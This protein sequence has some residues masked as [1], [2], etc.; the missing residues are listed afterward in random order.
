MARK[1]VTDEQPK[2]ES[3]A[4]REQ[5]LDKLFAELSE[6][7]GVIAGSPARVKAVRDRM[8]FKYIPTPVPALN[9][10]LGE[11][12]PRGHM[13]LIAGRSDSGKTGFCLNTIGDAMKRDKDFIALWVESEDSI[14]IDQVAALYGIDLDRFYCVSTT[15]PVT[16]KQ[17][18]G[19]EAIGDAIIKILREVNMDICVINSLKMLVPMKE[20]TKN[21][22]EDTIALQARFNAKL[23]KKLIP[24]CAQRD[25]AMVIIQHYTTNMAAGLYG[26]PEMIGGGKAIRYNN[27]ATLEFSTLKLD[28]G[29]PVTPDEGMKIKVRITKNHCVIDRNPRADIVYYIEYGKG[30]EKYITTLNQLIKKGI[31]QQHGSWLSVDDADGNK[32]PNMSWQGRNRFKQDMIDNPVKFDTLCA[33][34]DGETGDVIPLSAEENAALDNAELELSSE[35]SE[36][37][38]VDVDE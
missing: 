29:D 24:L 8:T 9:E 37:E 36:T 3:L 1:K 10:A 32:D 28:D 5:T 11:G 6:Q 31:I 23:M 14:D 35:M 25:T 33:M 17:S 38:E 30:V 7:S 21:M 27:M 26:N 2:K 15:D 12:L 34:L 20:T 16:K 22:D 4:K 18:F 19:A 13:T